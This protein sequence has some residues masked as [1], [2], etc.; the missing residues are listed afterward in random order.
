MVKKASLFLAALL[1]LC[2]T[3]CVNLHNALS[4]EP[5][6]VKIDGETYRAGFYGSLW[7]KNLAFTGEEY[8]SDGKTYRRADCAGFDCMQTSGGGKT[9]GIVYCLSS[10]WEDAEAYYSNPEN[11]TYYLQIDSI[12][13]GKQ[14]FE[15]EDIDYEKFDALTSFGDIFAYDPFDSVKNK[16][17]ESREILIDA[18]EN[19]P[20][21]YFTFYKESKDGSFGSFKGHHFFLMDGKMYLARYHDRSEDMVSAVE[22]SEETSSCFIETFTPFLER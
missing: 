17:S 8:E 20:L 11:Y 21:T 5:E 18:S 6:K 19:D 14:V 4:P 7:T 3:G 10:Q 13:G 12:Q 9:G 22:L 1:A 15:I 2:L 16:A